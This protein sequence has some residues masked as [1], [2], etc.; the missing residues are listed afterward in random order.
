MAYRGHKS[1]SPPDRPSNSE[2]RMLGLGLRANVDRLYKKAI[3]G[4]GLLCVGTRVI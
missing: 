3:Q 2:L 4:S 1:L